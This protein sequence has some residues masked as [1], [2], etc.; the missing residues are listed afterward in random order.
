MDILIGIGIGVV[1]ETTALVVL[2][3]VVFYKLR[4]A[5]ILPQ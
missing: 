2:T 3:K 4:K 1:G 5:G